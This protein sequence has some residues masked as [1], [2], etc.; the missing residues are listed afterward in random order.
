MTEPNQN[1]NAPA[2]PQADQQPQSDEVLTAEEQAQLQELK[3][4]QAEYQA[5][6]AAAELELTRQRDA[7]VERR[8]AE[9]MRD[10]LAQSG[11]KFEDGSQD[12]VLKLA[13]QEYDLRYDAATGSFS[14]RIDGEPASLTD[15]MRAV[16]SKYP[17]LTD[18]SGELNSTPAA[19]LSRDSMTREQKIAYI[20]RHGLESYE[21]LPLTA[22]KPDH[23]LS[24]AEYRALP[25]R[26]RA[27]LV[28]K[29]GADWV[30]R[31]AR[32]DED[33]RQRL[34]QLEMKQRIAEQQRRNR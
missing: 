33:E 21:R 14:A 31:L 9:A 32:R 18:R 29:Y 6:A 20:G 24:F 5:R 4:K 16:A 17:Y 7:L 27:E 1:P 3:T 23:Q 12:L 11:V 10:A 25:L 34:E 26:E 2:Q 28:G 15:A 19:P 8:K 30:A 22:R 13:A